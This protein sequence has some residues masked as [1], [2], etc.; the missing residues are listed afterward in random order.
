MIQNSDGAHGHDSNNV[1]ALKHRMQE[2]VGSWKTDRKK[3]SIFSGEARTTPTLKF[4]M[5]LMT[6]NSDRGHGRHSTD[7][8]ELKFH[9]QDSK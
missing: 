8:A 5:T 6:L 3:G 2:E 1:A 9:I 7:M 4:K